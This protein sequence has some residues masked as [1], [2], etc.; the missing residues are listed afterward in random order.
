MRLLVPDEGR[1]EETGEREGEA[2]LLKTEKRGR[3]LPFENAVL[4]RLDAWHFLCL[5][6]AVYI[7][8]E[9]IVRPLPQIVILPPFSP[10]I[11]TLEW[12]QKLLKGS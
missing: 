4:R 2:Q 1:T 7:A 11:I 9:Q 3:T 8:L 5:T 6:G 12:F 10:L